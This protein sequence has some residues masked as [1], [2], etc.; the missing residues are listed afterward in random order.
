MWIASGAALVALS[1]PGV[2]RPAGA[3][4]IPHTLDH[5]RALAMQIGS[6]FRAY[7][8]G[9]GT[10]IAESNVGARKAWAVVVGNPPLSAANAGFKLPPMSVQGTLPH[11]RAK[12]T[13]NVLQVFGSATQVCVV[14]YKSGAQTGAFPAK[15]SGVLKGPGTVTLT[16]D[17]ITMQP[18]VMY[19]AR[20]VLV[21]LSNIAEGGIN[22]GVVTVTEIK[23]EF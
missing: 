5:A 22:G 20:A 1:V 11:A 3:Q 23:W 14:I 10:Y 2:L 7:A 12:A 16:T 6:S 15:N 21:S 17:E 9:A 19:E 8:E 4:T 13:F 18:G